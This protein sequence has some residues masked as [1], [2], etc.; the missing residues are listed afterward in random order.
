MI[1]NQYEYWKKL[2]LEQILE[3]LHQNELN[4]ISNCNKAYPS[5]FLIKNINRIF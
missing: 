2:T 1:A 3:M 4:K 5:T